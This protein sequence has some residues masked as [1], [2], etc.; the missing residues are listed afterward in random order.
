M[1]AAVLRGLRELVIEE[2]PMP[3]IGPKDI[4]LRSRAC[5]ICGTDVHIYEI[6]RAHV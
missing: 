3:V 2:A 4:L 1:K 5:G 6:G